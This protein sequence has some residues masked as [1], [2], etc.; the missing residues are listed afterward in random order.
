MPLPA[1]GGVKAVTLRT[2]ITRQK[3]T[4]GM[5]EQDQIRPSR[6][7]SRLHRGLPD[8]TRIPRVLPTMHPGLDWRRDLVAQ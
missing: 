2:R 3:P 8:L 1:K 7:K 4:A 5:S 6:D